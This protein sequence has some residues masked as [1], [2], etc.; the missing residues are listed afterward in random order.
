MDENPSTTEGV[1]TIMNW[2]QELAPV[3][4][5]T[6]THGD[7]LS[8]ERMTDAKR[9]SNANMTTDKRLEMLEQ[10]PGEFHHRGIML[11]YILNNFWDANSANEEL[12][13]N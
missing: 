9:A 10:V 2:L 6:P 3:N 7:Q 11:Q 8:H 12:L 5:V 4:R 13:C 1:V